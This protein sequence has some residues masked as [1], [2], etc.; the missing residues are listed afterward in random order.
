M[1]EAF[2]PIAE[3]GTLLTRLRT[4]VLLNTQ[5]D[6]RLNTMTISWGTLGIEW[7][8]PL[9]TTVVRESRFTL[10]LLRKNASFTISIPADD[11]AKAILAFCGSKSGRDVD[12]IAH[13]GLTPEAAEKNGVPGFRELPITLECKVVQHQLQDLDTLE[14]AHRAKWYPAPEDRHIA[15]VGEII[16][17]YRI[18]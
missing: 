5:A 10:E 6:G 16:A 18:R 13:L 3:A 15:F 1:K 14:P 7:G 11:T 17:A 12:K 2:D 4:G 9:F 8:K